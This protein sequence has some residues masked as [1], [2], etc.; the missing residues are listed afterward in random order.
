MESSHDKYDWIVIG[1]GISGISIAEILCREGKTVLLIEKNKKVASETSKIFHEWLHS[2]SLYS[3]L[4][5]NSLTS[6]Y[7]LGATDDLLEY[8]GSY[9]GMNL[10]PT[11]CGLSVNKNEKGWFFKECI[12]YKY[13][14]RKLNPLWMTMV[15]RSIHITNNIKKHDWLR[16]R[17]GG[18]CNTPT[19]KAKN[20]IK[21]VSDQI[22][23]N[24][25]FLSITS[26]DLKINSRRLISD[27]IS[28][29]V[30][31][32]LN[33]VTDQEVL[34]VNE[35]LNEVRIKTTKNE[36][37]SRRV[38]VCSPDLISKLFDFPISIGYAP[39]AIVK[40]IPS[41]ESSFV[42]LDYKIK[43]CINLLIKPGGIGQAGGITVK[44][45]NEIKSYLDYIIKKHKKRNPEI[46]VI[47]TYVGLKKELPSK[48]KDRNYLYSIDQKSPKIWSIVLGKFTLAFSMAPEFYRRVY[49]ENP[50]KFFK[51]NNLVKIHKSISETSWQQIINSKKGSE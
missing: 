35:K 12:T 50:R 49:K 41:N 31:K 20:L 46:Q 29:S 17:A 43:N 8:Y 38:V 3:L 24:Q 42:E 34:S 32:G 47:D 19:L 23:H 22:K 10:T 48:N 44:S 6:R 16:K 51:D 1:G 40:N 14:V 25:D 27:L 9:N 45:K 15:S 5:D 11:E 7:L 30:S 39:I 13:K 37:V 18:D 21:L 4:P 2:G 26:P 28:N 36:Y 33:I